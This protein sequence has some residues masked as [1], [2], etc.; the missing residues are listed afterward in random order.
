MS[1]LAHFN[2][3]SI[4]VERKRVPDTALADDGQPWPMLR[5]VVGVFFSSRT[6]STALS[7]MAERTFDLPLVGETLNSAA[8]SAHAERQGQTNLQT[9][10]KALIGAAAPSAGGSGWFMFKAGVPGLVNAARIGFADQYRAQIH[11]ILL[12]RRDGLGQAL[13]ILAANRTRKYHSTQAAKR[14]LQEEDYDYQFLTQQL[15]I[16]TRANA[17]IGKAM[18]WFPIPAQVLLYEDFQQGDEA[19]VIAALTATGLPVR[20]VPVENPHRVVQ[21]ITHPLAQQFRARFMA[22]CH[23]EAA[24]LLAAHEAFVDGWTGRA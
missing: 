6:G 7:R 9:T 2:P 22:E 5:G 19:P 10:L 24:D 4:V 12:L 8:L 15:R 11:P 18:G 1:L 16:I 17:A 23:G 13:S 21:R 20:A 14:P 3:H